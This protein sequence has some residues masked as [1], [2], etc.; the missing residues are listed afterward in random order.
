MFKGFLKIQ[1][2]IKNLKKKK[3]KGFFLSLELV[4]FLPILITIF[5]CFFRIIQA[6]KQSS[7]REDLLLRQVIILSLTN[8][9]DGEFEALKWLEENIDFSSEKGISEN[10]GDVTIYL[11]NGKIIEIKSKEK[12]K[13]F[14]Y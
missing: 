4:I 5:L 10:N 2:I 13:F 9:Q 3:L 8:C 11:K 7:Q 6:Q 1:E 12:E 14:R